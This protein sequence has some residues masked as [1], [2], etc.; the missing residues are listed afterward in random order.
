[1]DWFQKL[2]LRFLSDGWPPSQAIQLAL[3]RKS[4]VEN[5]DRELMAEIRC[6]TCNRELS[7]SCGNLEEIL[8][9]HRGHSTVITPQAVTYS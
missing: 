9:P 5:P 3:Y 2:A 4:L 8:G 1:M 6:L 7:S